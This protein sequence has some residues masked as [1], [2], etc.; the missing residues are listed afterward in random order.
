[1]E[2]AH[3]QPHNRSDQASI[4]GVIGL[5]PCRS[6]RCCHDGRCL[7]SQ[8][9]ERFFSASSGSRWLISFVLHPDGPGDAR[10]LVGERAGRLVVV[11]TVLDGEGPGSKAIEVAAGAP[12]HGSRA[13][14]RACPV[15]E[16][17]PDVTVAAL[18]DA[19]QVAGAARGVLA[20][21]EAKE[22]R[23]APARVERSWVAHG[24]EHRGAGQKADARHARECV[25]SGALPRH[26]GELTFELLDARL[27]QP[28]F[29]ERQ[30]HRSAQDRRDCRVIVGDKPRDLRQ[31][32]HGA[33]RH[34]HA[35]FPAKSSQRV[36]A[37]R[38]RGHPRRAHAVKRLQSL[39]F[40]RLHRHWLDVAGASRFKQCNRVRGVGL[41]PLHVG[42]HILRR[43]QPYFYS[44]AAKRACPMMRGAAGFHHH[45]LHRPVVEPPCKLRPRQ[46]RFLD[47]LPAPIGGSELEDVLGQINGNGS[48]IHL[49]LL[50]SIVLKPPKASAGSMMPNKEREESIPS[51][52]TD[53]RKSGARPSPR[54]LGDLSLRL[55]NLQTKQRIAWL[56]TAGATPPLFFMVTGLD[57]MWPLSAYL[58]PTQLQM[59]VASGYPNTHIWFWEVF[60][61][62]LV[63]NVVLYLGLG[64]ILLWL[65]HDLLWTKV[66]KRATAN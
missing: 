24:G 43:Q 1:M 3:R 29:L 61:I 38:P 20:R 52:E 54:T 4:S 56:S 39:L 63:C 11:G 50:L 44:S 35:E 17:H 49:G 10:E 65:L 16:Q 42:T 47:Y 40:D 48:S 2:S 21:G 22:A 33:H 12:C 62:S 27:H 5:V 25:T 41:V 51:V 66:I 36:N 19:S 32:A 23:I 26:L 57:F 9:A 15:G 8:T 13:E 46:S 60:A 31:A 14:H 34:L 30:T 18:R 45:Q 58:W 55:I 53:A 7:S 37:T 6:D 64:F 28:D 59:M